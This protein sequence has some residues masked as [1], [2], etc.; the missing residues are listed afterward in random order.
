MRAFESACAASGV[1]CYFEMAIIKSAILHLAIRVG[2][3]QE[4]E[5][6]SG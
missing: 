2:R 4:F 3:R 6:R 1:I 5:H